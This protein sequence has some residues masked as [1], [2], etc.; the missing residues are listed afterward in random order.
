[1]D[2]KTTSGV[3]LPTQPS[4]AFYNARVDFFPQNDLMFV[5]DI[6]NTIG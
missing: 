6:T 1:M 5:F 4:H 3:G 2:A